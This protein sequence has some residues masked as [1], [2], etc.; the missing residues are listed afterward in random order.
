MVSN[1]LVVL[2][3]ERGAQPVVNWGTIY[4]QR[5]GSTDV[6]LPWPLHAARLVRIDPPVLAAIQR[7]ADGDA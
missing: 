6:A 5:P 1:L 4:Q 3:G 2:S 7:W